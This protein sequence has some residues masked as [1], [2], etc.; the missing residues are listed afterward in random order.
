MSTSRTMPPPIPVSIPRRAAI[1]G[2]RPKPSAFCVPDTAKSASP[3]PS[4]TRTEL[5]NWS[6]GGKPVERDSARQKGN[7]EISPIGERRWR[8]RADHEIASDASKISCNERQDENAEYVEPSPDP[9]GGSAER[10]DKRPK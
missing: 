4:K 1:T 7:G 9:S 2:L 8:N 5:R 3:A 10:E 6:M